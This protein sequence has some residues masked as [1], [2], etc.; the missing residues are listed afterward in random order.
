M[1]AQFEAKLEAKLTAKLAHFQQQMRDEFQQ[2]LDKR[3]Q[4]LEAR[5]PTLE[6]QIDSLIDEHFKIFENKL[7]TFCTQLR[8]Q[9]GLMVVEALALLP[10]SVTKSPVIGCSHHRS[11]DWLPTETLHSPVPV[12]ESPPQ[13]ESGS[14]RQRTCPAAPLPEPT[15]FQL[16][17]YSAPGTT[18]STQASALLDKRIA[19]PS[20][21]LSGSGSTATMR[22][23]YVQHLLFLQALALLP[24]SVTKSPVIGCSHYRSKDWLPT[25]TLHS[26]VPVFESPPQLESGSSRQRTCPAA[27]LPEPTL[28]QLPSYSAPGTTGST[29]ASALLDK[30]IAAPSLPL[31][32]SGSTATMRSPYVQ[33]LL[34]L[35]QFLDKRLQALEA[36]FPTLEA[37][38]DSLIDEH[39]KIFENKLDTFCT[40][41]RTQMGLM[42]V[43]ALALLPLSVTKS[44]VIGCSHHRSKDW[45]PTETL[46]SPVPV[47]ESPPQLESGSSRQRT[48][49]AA[50]L[51]EPTLF[52]LPSYSAPGTTGSTQASALL[53][54]RIAAPSLPLSGSGSTATM[55][56]PYVQH[57]LFLQALALLPLSVTKSPVI[58]CSHY[59]S[60]DWLP[61]ETLHSPVP[62]FESPPQLESG[63]SR[64]RTC[65]AAPLPEPTLFQLPSYSAPGT[66]GSTQAS[67]LLDKR[68][69]A[70]SLPLSGSGSTATMRSP[71]VQHLLF[72]Q[73][74][75]LLPLSVTKSPVIGCSHHRSKDWLPTET[76]HSPVPVFESPPQL[77]SGSSRQRTCPAAPLP[78][79]TLFQLPSYSAPGTTG[80]TQASALL[81]K[82]IAA[83]SLPLSG[84][85]STAM[86]RSPYVQHLLFLQAL[87]L[88]PLSVTKSPVIGCS[89]YRSKD[90]LPT[91]TLH[92]PVP[93]FE[94]PPQLESGSSRQCTCPAAPLPEPTLFQLPSYSAPGTT[95]ST[96][97]SALLDKRIAAPSLP[98]SGSGSTATMRSPYVQHLLF[99]QVD[100]NTCWSCVPAPGPGPAYW[101][102]ANRR[103]YA[104]PSEPSPPSH[105][106][107]A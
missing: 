57:L 72:L 8:T 9:M 70:P 5:F 106:H 96:Q 59:R 13:L 46:H 11:K 97:A 74:L 90:W 66:T 3:L 27:P 54:K 36:R 52:Q 6:A 34:F 77:E 61:T 18:G 94:S 2:F 53:D 37:Q 76:L 41:L 63:S 35:Q 47:F 30:R 20:L 50:P 84:S 78:E 88:L 10:L 51:P 62:V 67:A 83:P 55:R 43:E 100:P 25:E 7:D 107:E 32:G 39:F 31:S 79:P 75:A 101:R 21:P 102:V 98:L 91:E 24:L 104:P 45:L 38:I 60:K 68:I 49:P 89:H 17:S 58:G 92:S 12:F 4:A 33:H 15:L 28:F 23:P 42:V 103:P 19:A 82:R 80:S 64:Q 93:V 26:P 69:A 29:Q 99:L 87:A 81:D 71:Y 73:A 85:G 86:M 16:P 95:G 1:E 22:S 48:C 105:H 40:Q 14:S 65:P 56:S 44:P